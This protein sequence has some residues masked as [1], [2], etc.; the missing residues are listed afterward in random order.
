[1]ASTMPCHACHARAQPL[2]LLCR[3]ILRP[4]FIAR[5]CRHCKSDCV[6]S[7]F[8]SLSFISS[9]VTNNINSKLASRQ[10]AC[11]VPH[12]GPGSTCGTCVHR[13]L[14][15]IRAVCVCDP[16][17]HASI[18]ARHKIVAVWRSVQR[19]GKLYQPPTV[20]PQSRLCALSQL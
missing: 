2:P 1:M 4:N 18:H 7:T 11:N 19:S 8:D 6:I 15:Q 3:T 16:C 12:D 5:D 13:S 17:K 14:T 10:A 9:A 20:Y